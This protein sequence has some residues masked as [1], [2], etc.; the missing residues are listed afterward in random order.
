M[1]GIDLKR[2]QAPRYGMTMKQIIAPGGQWEVLSDMGGPTF[3]MWNPLGT[4]LYVFVSI[5]SI[6]EFDNE[7]E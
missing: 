5:E 6:G 2:D 4:H 7:P 3:R 1:L